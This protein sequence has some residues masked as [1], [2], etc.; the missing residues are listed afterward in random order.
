MW[1]YLLYLR[2]ER[3]WESSMWYP[4]V[5]LQEL[6]HR[7]GE[8]QLIGP[9]LHLCPGQV[10]LHHELGQVTH[11]LRGGSHLRQ[12]KRNLCVT[13]HVKSLLLFRKRKVEDKE[14]IS[15]V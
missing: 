2:S 13:V 12:R 6:Y 9:F 8:G 11:D 7:Q 5:S 14:N 3:L 1:D 10:V 15:S 4:N